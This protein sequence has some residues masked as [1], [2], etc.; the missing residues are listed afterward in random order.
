MTTQPLDDLIVV[1]ISVTLP[2]PYTSKLLTQLGAEVLS[3]EP[4]S[5][6]P[7]K[8]RGPKLSNGTGKV[9]ATLNEGK[10][11]MTVDL[12]D[13]RG[14]QVLRD[15][16][17][18]A[19]VFIEGFR[20]GV[21]DRLAVGP[22]ELLAVNEELIYCSLSG[23]GQ[24]GPRQNQPAHAL[25]YEGL[26]GLLNPDDPSPPRLPVAD[27]AGG[28]MLAVAVLAALRARDRGESGQYIDLGLYEVI[29]S[30]NLWNA[31]W[32][33]QD[34]E[35]DY[36]PLVGGEYPC[37]NTYETADGRHVTLGAMEPEFWERLC[38][39]LGCPEL[40]DDQFTPGGRE[41]DAYQGLQEHFR[42]R[43]RSEWVDR[44]GEDLPVAAVR[45]PSEV[46]G[47]SQ[48]ASRDRIFL[49]D[50]A[51]GETLHGFG[52][53]VTFSDLSTGVRGSKNDVLAMA[54]YDDERLHKLRDA[55]VLSNVR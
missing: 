36:D 51:T 50:S 9:Y 2:G 14:Q 48:L 34:G 20:P 10:K 42:Q 6:D 32:A 46:L 53:P 35:P 4:P 47:D 22:D 28:L 30:W 5:G 52:F 1:D 24:D 44:L 26:A 11:T 55:G 13:E 12:K 7:L 41:T 17:G 33:D 8:T 37:Y 29:A 39:E 40:V 18:E 43:T 3:V 21:V 49:V 27:F 23:F 38:R 19:D 54:G 31:A 16:A 45:S 15:L 25:N